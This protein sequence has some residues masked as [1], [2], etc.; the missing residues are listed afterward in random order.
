MIK[1]T[2]S[3][4]RRDVLRRGAAAVCG[5]ALGPAAVTRLAYANAPGANERINVGVIGTGVR[6]KYLIGNLPESARVTAICDCATSRMV[7]T[8]EPKTPFAEV[9]GPFRDTAASHCATY[10]DYRRMIDGEDLD[11]VIIATPDHHHVSAALLAL[12]AGLDVYV[13]KPLS[14]TIRE[15]RLLADAV[16]RTGR[17]LQVGSQQRTMEINRFACEFVRDGGLG[18]ISRVDL[19]NYPG[20][21]AAPDFP[22]EEVP[23]GFDWDLFLGPA[24]MRPYNK[25]LW[26]K[27]V[28]KVDGLMWRA[29]DL[30]RDY[31]GHLMTNWGGHNA[32]MVQYALGVDDTGP[33][34]VEPITTVGEDDLQRDWKRK[35]HKKTPPPSGAFLADRRFRPIRLTYASGIELNLLP[36][37]KT[38]TFY[39]EQGRMAISRNRF[40]CRPADLVTDG[41]DESIAR[42]WAGAGFV[43]RP[44]LQNWLDCIASGKTPN[45]PVEVGHRTATVCHLV[46]IARELDRSLQW[47]PAA[48]HFVDDQAANELID[49]PRRNGFQL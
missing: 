10:Q 32:D 21:F 36:D 16:A 15:G 2:Q 17:V 11:A 6:G 1:L 41:P 48:E 38:A 49:R 12:D 42:Q 8:L 26:V 35:W 4:S 33:V 31:S 44:H 14:L 34:K 45:A 9:L 40:V 30:Y 28:F 18:Q 5:L 29:W 27:D 22:E 37:V 13:E 43:A 47:N 46:N 23:R 24:P 19:P 20:P 3:F 7:D 25:K 39:G